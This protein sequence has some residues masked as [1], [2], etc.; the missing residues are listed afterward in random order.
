MNNKGQTLVVFVIILPIILFLLAL[1]IDYGLFSLENKKLND[2]V[3]DGV[4]YYL[5]NLEDS[6]VESKVIK[7]LESNTEDTTFEIDN[8][9]N[10]EITA[11]KSY[12]GI[13][14]IFNNNELD[15]KYIG[16]KDTKEIVKG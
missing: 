5:D 4:E 9:T 1:I 2:T 6:A 13:S 12:K 7:L 8:T 16:N 14:G 3:Y 11:H 10:I 15:I